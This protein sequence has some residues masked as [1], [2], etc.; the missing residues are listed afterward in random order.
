MRGVPAQPGERTGV[1]ATPEPALVIVT[2]AVIERH[3]AY[4]VARRPAGVHLAGLWE[5]PGGK[6]GP[7]ESLETCLAREIREELA[8]GV[9]VGDEIFSTRHAYP[10]RTVEL[11]FFACALQ[12][13]PEAALGQELRWVPRGDLRSLEFPPAD[14]ALIQQL[15]T[16]K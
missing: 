8:C 15:A 10:E 6:C 3:G 2:A 1:T 9:T 4:L 14:E 12:G 13:E 5:F 11:H 16:K 7:E